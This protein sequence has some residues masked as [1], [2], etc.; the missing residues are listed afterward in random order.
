M[1]SDCLASVLNILHHLDLWQAVSALPRHDLGLG[2]LASA[3]FSK[4]KM[5]HPHH[6]ECLFEKLYYLPYLRFT[7]AMTAN[8]VT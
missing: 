8:A 5:P 2:C 4:K 3:S 1:V 7:L 6:R